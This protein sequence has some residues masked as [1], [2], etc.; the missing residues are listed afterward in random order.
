MEIKII[1][2][3]TQKTIVKG[4]YESIKECLEK[5]SG[6]YLHDAYLGGAD[7][8]GADLHGADLRGA[9]L[10]GAYLHDAYLRGADLGGADLGGADL[11]GADLRGA[12]LRG[13][14]LHDADL[15]GAYLHDVDLRGIKEISES[16]AIFTE[17]CRRQKV[18]T[19]TQKEWSMIAIVS[20]HFIC[21]DSIKKRFGKDMLTVFK[22]IK[23]AG[24]PDYLTKYKEVLEVE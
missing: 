10:R 7:L 3:F 19:F 9:D 14:Y 5:N 6:A 23:D 8:G 15:R 20:I 18:E 13:A 1:N 4:K 17:L 22:K 11:H 21:W 24:W 16:H 12:D 2:R